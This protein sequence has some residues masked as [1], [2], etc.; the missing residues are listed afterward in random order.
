MCVLSLMGTWFQRFIWIPLGLCLLGGLV[1]GSQSNSLT[2]KGPSLAKGRYVRTVLVDGLSR[3]YII[4]V[5]PAASQ[6]T[7]LPVVVVL[8]GFTASGSLAEIYT[9]MAEEGDRRG[10]VTV[11]PDGLGTQRGWNAGFIDLSGQRPNDVKFID[12]V[13]DEV[14]RELPI[15]P[16]REY[17][18]GHSNGAFLTHYIGA[19]RAERFAAI[20]VVAGTVGLSMNSP[21]SHIP[22][23]SGPLS[24]M[25]IHG[26]KDRI[27]GYETSAKALMSG[28]S[29]P[30]SALWWAK[31]DRCNLTP[32]VSSDPTGNVV[33]TTYS[34]GTASTD[35][36][37][38]SIKNGTHA[39]PG[40]FSELGLETLTKVNAASLLF[41][42]FETH[43]K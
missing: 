25:I 30:D 36:C 33:T 11:F 28:V 24:V 35:V 1:A 23:E 20:G 27:V 41:S 10:Y 12:T 43:V 31:Q 22:N 4:R 38:V 2:A 21:Q 8:H 32:Q 19:K 42:F 14:Q 34:H 17:L 5:P 29:A 15:D 40:G 39:W 3:T 9:R 13:L 37:L 6:A 16:H 18:A 7:S 26:Q